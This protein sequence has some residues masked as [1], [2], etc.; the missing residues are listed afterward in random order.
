MTTT[1]QNTGLSWNNLF[2][3]GSVVDIDAGRWYA[4]TKIRPEDFGITDSPEVAKALSLG[5]H[6]LAPAEAFEEIQGI[7]NRAKR[8]LE[9]HSL[10]FSMIQ[11]ARY[12][13]SEQMEPLMMKLRE[14]RRQYAEA[15]DRFVANYDTVVKDMLP[16]IRAA[17]LDAC[18]GD[19]EVA[20]QAFNRIQS[21]YPTAAEI[22]S[23]FYFK[24]SIY[25]VQSAKGAAAAEAAEEEAESIKGVVKGMVEQLRTDLAEKVNGVMEVIRKGGKLKKQSLSAA[26]TCLDRTDALNVLGDVELSRQ[27]RAIRDALMNLD[28]EQDAP[29][30]T[31]DQLGTLKT[32]LEQGAAEAVAQAEAA[33]MGLGRR[34]LSV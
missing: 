9:F 1:T 15:L 20:S 19:M 11:G 22:R 28:P 7:V 13:P 21:E 5:N 17:L 33:L 8:A 24:W 2:L 32:E 25:A 23:K 4:R 12:V 16:T 26:L 29:V 31:I 18:K 6:R 14:A 30:G 10:R 3:T 27:V 34:K